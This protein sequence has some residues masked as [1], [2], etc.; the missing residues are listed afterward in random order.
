MNRKQLIF[1]ALVFCFALLP[2][3]SL[4][5][6]ET[7]SLAQPGTTPAFKLKSVDGKTYDVAEMRGQVLLASFGATWCTPCR[8]ELT[9]LEQIKAEYKNQPVRFV[10]VSIE[11]EEDISDS[12]LRH[13]AKEMKLT[14]PVL[15]DGDQ[16][17]FA[18]FTARR[19]MPMV[20]VFDKR[21]ALH[22]A[23][24]FGMGDAESYKARVREK[25]DTALGSGSSSRATNGG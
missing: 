21:G 18:Q 12:L 19:R 25:L 8:A 13:R 22:A 16:S 2:V 20:V 17:I 15:R 11:S 6:Q 4:R 9:A 24:M 10:W 1:F 7:K 5:A 3:T 14:M 23:P